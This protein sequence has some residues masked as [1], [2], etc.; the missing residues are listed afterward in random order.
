MIFVFA[1]QPLI[2]FQY[3]V[4]CGVQ[5]NFVY[6]MVNMHLVGGGGIKE[7]EEEEEHMSM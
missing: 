3:Y 5:C 2:V 1:T 4:L 6:C 7:K